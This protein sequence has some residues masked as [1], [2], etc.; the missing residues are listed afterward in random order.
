MD[1]N[2][3]SIYVLQIPSRN[4]GVNPLQDLEH[5]NIEVPV[6]GLLG[7]PVAIE[8]SSKF[9]ITKEVQLVCKYLKAYEMTIPSPFADGTEMKRIDTLYMESKWLYLVTFIVLP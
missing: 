4:A 2:Y 6:L 1:I 8:H 7:I 3:V 5:F 9:S